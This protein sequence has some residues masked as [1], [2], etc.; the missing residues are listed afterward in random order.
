[1]DRTVAVMNTQTAIDVDVP[2][3]RAFALI[4][5]FS[6]N[7]EWQEGMERCAWTSTGPLAVG[8]TY[9]QEARFLGKA[10]LSTFQVTELTPGR[11]VSIESVVSTFPIQVRRWVEPLGPEQ[12]R[13]HASVS[14]QPPWYMRL[15][16][17]ASMVAR[18]VAQDYT[19]LKA[20]L[21]S[22]E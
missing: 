14:G 2:S 19:R 12:C 4:S 9:E 16:G 15:P 21:E 1:M 22:A 11:S 17:M 13:I 5:D 10:I 3:A 20:L 8:S 18:S 7:P 6:R